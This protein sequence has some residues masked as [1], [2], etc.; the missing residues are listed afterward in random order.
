MKLT[1][2][3]KEL[4]NIP[5][6]LCYIRLLCVPAFA[7]V[8]FVLQGRPG[9]DAYAYMYSAL[10]VFAFASLTDVFDGKIARRFHMES[11][12]G[13]ALDPLADKLLQLMAVICLTVNGNVFWIFPV[14]IGVRELYQ[15][16]ASIMLVSKNIVGKA[17]YWGKAAAFVVAMGI[18]VAVFGG[19]RAWGGDHAISAGMIGH[20][21]GDNLTVGLALYWVA[22]GLLCV[23]TVLGWIAAANYTM[24]VVKQLGGVKKIKDSHDVRLDYFHNSSE[25]TLS[26]EEIAAQEAAEKEAQE[27]QEEAPQDEAEAPEQEAQEESAPQE[28]EKE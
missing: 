20:W 27:T 26:R 17:N 18:I 13:A 6:I 9:I 15:I 10:A 8:F 7:V 11:A 23:G 4:L 5:N 19:A 12:V 25:K 3:K 22:F 28:D 2:T 14:L 1:F 16:F 21:A 24:I